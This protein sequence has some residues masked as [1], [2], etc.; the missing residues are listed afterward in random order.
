LDDPVLYTY[1]RD[2]K[3]QIAKKIHEVLNNKSDKVRKLSIDRVKQIKFEKKWK[4][5]AG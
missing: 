4:K 3:V 2:E 5:F 1:T